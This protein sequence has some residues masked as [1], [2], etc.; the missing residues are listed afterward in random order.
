[1]FRAV[2]YVLTTQPNAKRALKVNLRSNEVVVGGKSAGVVDVT[3]GSEAVGVKSGRIAIVVVSDCS[4]SPI[5][6]VA[7]SVDKGPAFGKRIAFEVFEETT[8]FCSSAVAEVEFLLYAIP[9]DVSVCIADGANCK[10]AGQSVF[11]GGFGSATSM[12][13]YLKERKFVELED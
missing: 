6:T 1:M 4:G 12:T 2:R 13:K 3:C 5:V 7:V 10:V 11:I 9:L 8:G